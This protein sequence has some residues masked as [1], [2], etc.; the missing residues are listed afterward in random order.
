[1]LAGQGALEV[2]LGTLH[3]HLNYSPHVDPCKAMT[4]TSNS[5]IHLSK[6]EVLVQSPEAE[7]R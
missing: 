4:F 1:M 5:H 6:M 2:T 3:P 7:M